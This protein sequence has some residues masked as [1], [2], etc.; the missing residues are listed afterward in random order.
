MMAGAEGARRPPPV[1][2]VQTW[3]ARAAAKNPQ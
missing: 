1:R 2:V 3:L